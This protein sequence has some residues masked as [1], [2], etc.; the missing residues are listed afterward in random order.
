MVKIQIKL[1]KEENR[2]V[3]IHKAQKGFLTKAQ[4]IKDIIKRS[5]MQGGVR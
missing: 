1:T 3:N 5:N 4:A 2:I